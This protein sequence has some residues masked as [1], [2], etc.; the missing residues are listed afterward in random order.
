MSNLE[1]LNDLYYECSF[2]INNWVI[3]N[4]L[5]TNIVSQIECYM[6]TLR[7]LD[8]WKQQGL[9]LEKPTLS[10]T[11]TLIFWVH[12]SIIDTA[13]QLFGVQGGFRLG[14]LSECLPDSSQYNSKKQSPRPRRVLLD[15][16][17]DHPRLIEELTSLGLE[18]VRL[19]D[20]IA[21]LYHYEIIELCTSQY[22]DLVV[23]TNERF[24]NP[25]EEWLKYLMPHRTRLFF[26]PH[27]LLETPKVLAQAIHDRAYA[28]RKL[29]Q[30]NPHQLQHEFFRTLEQKSLEEF[31]PE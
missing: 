7:Q 9:L 11:S 10:L 6:E 2:P 13:L 14:K 23:T 27:K 4:D 3:G 19:W 30:P 1:Q 18:R 25:A 26:P 20:H 8:K 12:K 22:I 17:C 21:D 24:M 5:F 31:Q 29:K 16:G 28:K 15:I